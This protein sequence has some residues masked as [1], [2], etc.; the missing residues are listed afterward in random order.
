MEGEGVSNKQNCEGSRDDGDDKEKKRNFIRSL[1]LLPTFT[2]FHYKILPLLSSLVFLRW[3]LPVLVDIQSCSFRPLGYSL[4][5]SNSRRNVSPAFSS[6]HS[7]RGCNWASYSCEP[8]VCLTVMIIAQALSLP[9]IINWL[10][11]PH[12]FPQIPQLLAVPRTDLNG[13]LQHSLA[14]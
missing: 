4:A 9:L 1:S 11:Q 14:A 5:F 7:A 6:L 10:I 13:R 3:N 2:P 12:C 8:I